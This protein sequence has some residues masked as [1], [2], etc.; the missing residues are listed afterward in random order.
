M[1]SKKTKKQVHRRA[2]RFYDYLIDRKSQVIRY[3]TAALVTG[4]VQFLLQYFLPIDAFTGFI[5]RFLLFLPWLKFGVYKEKFN[6]FETLKQLM[7]A[8]MLVVL[9]QLGINYLIFF[10]TTLLGHGRIVSY[11]GIALLEVLY[12]ILFQFVVFKEKKD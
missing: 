8:I 11:V 2:D 3:I 6:L 4:V 12:F 9:L 1:A 7:I 5:L 10:M